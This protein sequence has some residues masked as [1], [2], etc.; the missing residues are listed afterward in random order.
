MT[1]LKKYNSV[2]G[3]WQ[4]VQ[5]GVPGENSTVPGPTG[6]TGATPTLVAAST[7]VSGIVEL[8]TAAETLAGTDAVRAVTPIGL[9]PLSSRLTATVAD[10][11]ALAALSTTNKLAGDLA[12]VV[13][14]AVY[15]SWTGAVWRQVTT[16]TFA[17][18]GA[19]DTAYAKAGA[20]YVVAGVRALDT[21]TGVESQRG[22]SAW[23]LDFQIYSTPFSMAAGFTELGQEAI[24]EGRS[25]TAT[26]TVRK[27]SNFGN[28]DVVAIII[29]ELRPRERVAGGG[30][31]NNNVAP[32]A[33]ALSPSGNLQV[34]GASGR[35]GTDSQ[36]LTVSYILA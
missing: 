21:S 3:L 13:E 24:R 6:P 22:A 20:V 25:V 28:I 35:A 10:F 36:I 30:F 32:R 2:S 9:E 34:F 26:I 17:S 8:A 19:R 5:V 16:A 14:G 7:T 1:V 4:P 31:D 27:S 12:F 15:M 18:T 29:P 23:V 11:T 33:N